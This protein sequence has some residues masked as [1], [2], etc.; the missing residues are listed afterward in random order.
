[1]TDPQR[2]LLLLVLQLLH[3]IRT[4]LNTDARRDAQP[5][6]AAT[7]AVLYDSS[8]APTLT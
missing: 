6:I 3:R 5:D 1:V 4:R 2:S 8:T 7:T